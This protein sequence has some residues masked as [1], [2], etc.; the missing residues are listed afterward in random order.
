M[1]AQ[2][3]AGSRIKNVVKK[4]ALRYDKFL[5]YVTGNVG[6]LIDIH[7]YVGSVVGSKSP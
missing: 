1:V 3:A 7:T 5:F 2:F 4:A 6:G